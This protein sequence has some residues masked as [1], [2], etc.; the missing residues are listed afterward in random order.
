MKWVCYSSH[1]THA[2]CQSLGQFGAVIAESHHLLFWSLMS[3]ELLWGVVR[4]ALLGRNWEQDMHVCLSHLP[5]RR[6]FG[7]GE[8]PVQCKDFKCAQPSLPPE[9]ESLSPSFMCFP[10]SFVTW[11][12]GQQENSGVGMSLCWVYSGSLSGHQCPLQLGVRSLRAAVA[13]LC[14]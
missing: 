10:P 3:L 5:A 13:L 1:L 7:K 11:G 6:D 4:V 2:S 8:K 14:A 9:L 12:M